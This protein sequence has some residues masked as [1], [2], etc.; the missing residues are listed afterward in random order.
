[1]MYEGELTI[2]SP[3]I[4]KYIVVLFGLYNGARTREKLERLIGILYQIGSNKGLLYR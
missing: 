1:M 4:V 3:F 2:C